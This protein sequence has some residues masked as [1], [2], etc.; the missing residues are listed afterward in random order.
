[1]PKVKFTNGNKPSL[2]Y[3]LA[4]VAIL[5]LFLNATKIT[6]RIFNKGAGSAILA[7]DVEVLKTN[8]K[9]L[10]TEVDTM[11]K[12]VTKD[13][14]NIALI[15]KD[16]EHMGETVDALFTAVITFM[17]AQQVINE[18]FHSHKLVDHN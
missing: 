8:V 5:A 17:Q 16:V 18:E 2:T 4:A 9:I 3:V 13:D 7:Q 15:Q 12:A 6:D 10:G 14:K 11:E 1:M